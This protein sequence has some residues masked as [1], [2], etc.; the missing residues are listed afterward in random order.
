MVDTWNAG[1]G[2]QRQFVSDGSVMCD[3]SK[4]VHPVCLV[5]VAMG[6]GHGYG[7]VG[8]D[9]WGGGVVTCFPSCQKHLALMVAHHWS[10]ASSMHLL[11]PEIKHW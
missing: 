10:E 1:A 3:L 11:R 8:G 4:S 2:N 6:A 9:I 5:S 7:P